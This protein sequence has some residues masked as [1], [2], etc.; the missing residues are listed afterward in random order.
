MTTWTDSPAS[1]LR[2]IAGRRGEGLSLT[3]LHLGDGAVVEDHGAD[4]LDVVVALAERAL[5]RLS[6]ERER[7]GH[8]RFERL[9]VSAS[10]PE[11]IGLGAKL[12]IV[13]ELHL[14]LDLVDSGDRLLELL[15]LLPLADAKGTVDQSSSWHAL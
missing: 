5:A 15:E 13:E 11:R 9:A 7:L 4:H 2:K 6:A 8:Q 12:R 14:R 3:G 10:F 1:E